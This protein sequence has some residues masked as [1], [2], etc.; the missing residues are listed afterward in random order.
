MTAMDAIFGDWCATP[1]LFSLCFQWVFLRFP[2]IHLHDFWWALANCCL[3]SLVAI[4]LQYVLYSGDDDDTD[5]VG[6]LY[7]S[8]DACCLGIFGV[9]FVTSA[10]HQ[11]S[12]ELF[13]V[14][15]FV[16]SSLFKLQRTEGKKKQ[17]KKIQFL[18]IREREREKCDLHIFHL[19]VAKLKKL[20]RR[21]E[22]ATMTPKNAKTYF[23]N[24]T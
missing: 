16:T 21:S 14:R 10:K 2:L 5:T 12:T 3:S 6:T 18:L 24:D 15:T 4:N 22:N 11:K 20:W 9:A 19:C 17:K 8:F 7:Y 13:F 23:R 1:D